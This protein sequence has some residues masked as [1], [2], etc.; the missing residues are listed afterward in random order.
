MAETDDK[1]KKENVKTDTDDEEKKEDTKTE[2]DE[3]SQQAGT[4]ISILTWMIMAVVVVLFAGSG[5]VLGRLFAGS[6]SPEIT[7]SSQ[8]NSK[9]EELMPDDL[10][11]NSKGTWYYNDLESVVVNPDEPGATRFVRVGLILEISSALN[12]ERAKELI[13]AKKPPLINWLNLYFKSLTLG[14]MENDRDMR[15]ILSQICDSFNEILFPDA[16]PQI[17]RILIREFNVQ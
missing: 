7:E 11:T 2:E 10:K 8:E 5:F 4:K 9:T 17:K 1:E 12:Q 16:K 6:P 14:E 13:D 15:R 3:Q